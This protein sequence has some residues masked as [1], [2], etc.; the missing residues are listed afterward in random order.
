MGY[1]FVP[2]KYTEVGEALLL[3]EESQPLTTPQS[4]AMLLIMCGN[5]SRMA[6]LAFRRSGTSQPAAVYRHT[7]THTHT[8]N[9]HKSH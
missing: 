2:L 8:K 9:E 5:S 6:L 3:R 4:K 1:T 7:H